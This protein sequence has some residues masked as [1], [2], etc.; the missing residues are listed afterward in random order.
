MVMQLL[1]EERRALF[2]SKQFTLPSKASE[3][4]DKPCTV[5]VF[6]HGTV[7]T[8][9]SEKQLTEFIIDPGLRHLFP[10]STYLYQRAVLV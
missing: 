7:G 6:G 5:W 10:G 9:S 3:V 4:L 1:L 2:L 8:F